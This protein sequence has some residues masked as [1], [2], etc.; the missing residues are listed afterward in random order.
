M[1]NLEL[2]LSIYLGVISAA[3]LFQNLKTIEI[4]D[5]MNRIADA[6]D[7]DEEDDE[8]DEEWR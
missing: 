2:V 7:G 6:M 8:D 3:L 4:K 5:A 1:S